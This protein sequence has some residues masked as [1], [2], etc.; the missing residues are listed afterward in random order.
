MTELGATVERGDRKGIS[1]KWSVQDGIYY[2][3]GDASAPGNTNFEDLLA[4]S[5]PALKI[6][7]GPGY[8][9]CQSLGTHRPPFTGYTFS[10][11]MP[12]GTYPGTKTILYFDNDIAP[13]N[14]F[15][16]AN[17]LIENIVFDSSGALANIPVLLTPGND[18][19]VQNCD[20]R[21]NLIHA[22]GAWVNLGQ[23]SKLEN[24]QFSGYPSGHPSACVKITGN[25]NHVEGCTFGSANYVDTIAIEMVASGG[26]SYYGNIIKN[27]RALI[28]DLSGIFVKINLKN[29]QHMI[30]DNW[31]KLFPPSATSTSQFIQIETIGGP[32]SGEGKHIIKGNNVDAL[33]TGPYRDGSLYPLFGIGQPYCVVDSNVVTASWYGYYQNWRND[34]I[35]QFT[36]D[37]GYCVLSNNVC[38]LYRCAP[39]YIAGAYCSVLNNI[40]ANCACSQALTQKTGAIILGN[41][42]DIVAYTRVIGN[43]IDWIQENGSNTW[44]SYGIVTKTTLD[45][46]T[47]NCVIMG[48]HGNI[49]DAGSGDGY[50]INSAD[51]E[52]CCFIGNNKGG[53]VN[54]FDGDGS[55]NQ[56][57]AGNT[58]QPGANWEPAPPPPPP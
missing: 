15:C 50:L 7:L 2:V 32:P 57:G 48:N 56:F 33:Q 31:V 24:C 41:G 21:A 46:R 36:E 19:V 40:F 1:S 25:N 54:V 12:G 34:S 53:A 6:Q 29:Q 22:S 55:D 45:D 20:F 18:S 10:G 17:C 44:D 5:E 14:M 4:S 30:L 3:P 27:N 9:R 51:M 47:R 35:F 8:H 39:V 37:A 58:G 43:Y 16:G 23:N 49:T 52:H 28:G 26:S 13:N 42:D 38:D 11:A